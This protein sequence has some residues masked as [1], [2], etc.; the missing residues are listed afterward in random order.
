MT[1]LPSLSSYTVKAAPQQWVPAINNSA[2]V[3][4]GLSTVASGWKKFDDMWGLRQTKNAE[5]IDRTIGF[6]PAI[7]AAGIHYWLGKAGLDIDKVILGRVK[8]EGTTEFQFELEPGNI[9]GYVGAVGYSALRAIVVLFLGLSLFYE[10]A[11]QGLEVTAEGKAQVKEQ[12]YIFIISTG[13]LFIMPQIVDLVVYMR[14]QVLVLLADKLSTGTTMDLGNLYWENYCESPGILNAVLYLGSIALYLYF[15]LIYIGIAVATTALFA[16]FPVVVLM[17]MREKGT[18][19]SWLKTMV[20]QLTV[21]CIDFFLLFIPIKLNKA[22]NPSGLS[23]ASLVASKNPGAAAKVFIGSILTMI[24]MY[25][26]VPMRNVVSQM[27][28]LGGGAGGEAGIGAAKAFAAKVR[29][30]SRLAAAG[31]GLISAWRGGKQDSLERERLDNED[32]QK[33]QDNHIYQAGMGKADGGKIRTD[34]GVDTGE[35]NA[36][37]RSNSSQSSQPQQGYAL[38]DNGGNSS[39]NSQA[40]AATEP[41]NQSNGLPHNSLNEQQMG[42]NDSGS[43]RTDNASTGDS[44]PQYNMARVQNLQNLDDARLQQQSTRTSYNEAKGKLET[45]QTRYNEAQTAKNEFVQ[46]RIDSGMSKKEARAE[47]NQ[48]HGKEFREAKENLDSAQANFANAQAENDK[49]T[50]RVNQ[51]EQA[52]Q[53]FANGGD[54][55][56]SADEYKEAMGNQNDNFAPGGDAANGG[57]TYNGSPQFSAG[58]VQGTQEPST[59]SPRNKRKEDMAMRLSS[60]Q[61]YQEPARLKEMA[62]DARAT[63]G[64]AGS[65]WATA[66]QPVQMTDAKTG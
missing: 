30:G 24:T 55:Y 46:Q 12:V 52:E 54:T 28:G 3:T 40:Q 57:G 45:A 31:A 58:Q 17:G 53:N 29:A 42:A 49:A 20:T 1:V 50:D 10:M 38:P 59:G 60:L 56:S 13:A 39:G 43:P 32:M 23:V 4:G 18:I 64:V 66:Q 41:V 9:Y 27:I 16:F 61:G 62:P 35:S 14:D 7:V 19:T 25:M 34:L 8:G 6:I 51:F 33:E 44:T 36:Q 65:Y 2:G 11:K 22:M 63:Y 26:I 47:Y 5:W 48:E 37:M 21:P 15:M